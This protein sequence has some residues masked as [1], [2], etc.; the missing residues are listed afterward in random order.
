MKAG[1]KETEKQRNE[2]DKRDQAEGAGRDT[3]LE[4]PRP[5]ME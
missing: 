4:S 3:G 2:E 1:R 5:A